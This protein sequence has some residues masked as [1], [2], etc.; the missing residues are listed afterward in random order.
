MTPR[1]TRQKLG[2]AFLGKWRR[3]LDNGRLPLKQSSIN[4]PLSVSVTSPWRHRRSFISLP[5]AGCLIS[6]AA[7][8][9]RPARARFFL[10]SRRSRKGE[11]PKRH[12]R[13]LSARNPDRRAEGK[14]DVIVRRHRRA[15]FDRTSSVDRGDKRVR[16]LIKGSVET[17]QYISTLRPDYHPCMQYVTRPFTVIR[18]TASGG[19][20]NVT[21]WYPSVCPSVPSVYSPW[22]TRGQ[23]ATRLAYISSWQ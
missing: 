17:T 18:L 23:H 21:V 16:S 11:S 22:L 1:S 2:R 14:C 6:G 3:F 8:L 9:R 5:P 13:I 4:T 20:Q 12:A 10:S 19:K 7:A 15:S